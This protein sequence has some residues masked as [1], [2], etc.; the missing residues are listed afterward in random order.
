M[1]REAWLGTPFAAPSVVGPAAWL[2]G[3]AGRQA[4]RNAGGRPIRS[5]AP[6]VASLTLIG[7]WRQWPPAPF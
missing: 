1:A 7:G 5:L 4:A 6:A 2:G 3:P